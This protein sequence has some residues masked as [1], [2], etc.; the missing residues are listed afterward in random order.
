MLLLT[1]LLAAQA[2]EP[3][4]LPC[5]FA[6]GAV[7]RY[8]VASTDERKGADGSIQRVASQTEQAF[9]VVSWDAPK[10][11]FE[12]ATGQTRYTDPPDDPIS[13][14][15]GERL[16]SEPPTLRVE[17]DTDT[18]ALRLLNLDE[19][20]LAWQAG[21]TAVKEVLADQEPPVPPQVLAGL[22]ALFTPALV[23][24][25]SL[26]PVQATLTYSCG[27]FHGGVMPYEHALPNPFGGAP[28]PAQ[29]TVTASRPEAGVVRFDVVERLD[30]LKAAAVLQ[31]LLEKM[32]VQVPAGQDDL[33]DA[34]QLEVGTTLQVDV[35][36]ATGW[37]RSWRTS[38][39][40]AA[41]GQ[42]RVTTV[43]AVRASA[44]AP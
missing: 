37:P 24:Q 39:T 16:G 28:L 34:I 25:K 21:I 20:T 31:P 38:R 5:N 15:L 40:I 4:S 35:D 17:L 10:A 42:H 12:V 3:V 27:D 11:V 19:V 36:A 13:L 23:E 30:A 7:H 33:L 9:T 29:G 18:T 32:Q 44:D 2:Q 6:P 26:E 14:T 43:T 1:L 41:G 8:T 22:D